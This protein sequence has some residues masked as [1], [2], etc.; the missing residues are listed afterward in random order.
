[1]LI[2][3]QTELE[4]IN[5]VILFIN[6]LGVIQVVYLF[7]KFVNNF[8]SVVNQSYFWLNF[9]HVFFA[10]DARNINET[11]FMERVGILRLF[12]LLKS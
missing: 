4:I 6:E 9:N 1:M 10:F 11:L 2:L 3:M 12:C 7:F 5:E 8:E